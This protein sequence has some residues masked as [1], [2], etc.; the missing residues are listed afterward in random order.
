[1]FGFAVF[2]HIVDEEAAVAGVETQREVIEDKQVGI[3][4][5]NWARCPHDMVD[6]F[7]F[8]VIFNRFI[9]DQ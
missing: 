2:P 9:R 5:Q 3:L 8:G 7:C 6:I 1:M 4:C